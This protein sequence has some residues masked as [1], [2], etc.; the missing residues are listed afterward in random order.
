MN[1]RCR[2]TFIA[3]SAKGHS[4]T[5]SER[6]LSLRDLTSFQIL[7]AF[8]QLR[9]IRALSLG[10]FSP[11]STGLHAS[12]VIEEWSRER[13]KSSLRSEAWSER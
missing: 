11:S 9:R 1:D 8:R 12:P 4:F 3:L 5:L 2:A 13:R 6:C 7:V 10:R